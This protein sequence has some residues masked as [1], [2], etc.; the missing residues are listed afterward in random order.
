MSPSIQVFPKALQCKGSCLFPATALELLYLKTFKAFIQREVTH[1]KAQKHKLERFFLCG[2]FLGT[3]T[4]RSSS[5]YLN[6]LSQPSLNSTTRIHE[7]QPAAGKPALSVSRMAQLK[8]FS[9]LKKSKISELQR[10]VFNQ[11]HQIS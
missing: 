10:A 6:V 9:S 4:T 3:R 1:Q 7:T 2:S 8:M 5:M 11:Y